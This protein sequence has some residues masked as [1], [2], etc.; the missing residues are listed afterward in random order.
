MVGPDVSEIV[1]LAKNE[2]PQA[3]EQ[4]GRTKGFPSFASSPAVHDGPAVDS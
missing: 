2:G 3:V 1:V 4:A